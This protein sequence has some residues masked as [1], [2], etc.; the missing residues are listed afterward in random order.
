MRDDDIAKE[1][2]AAAHRGDAAAAKDVLAAP[3]GSDFKA[4]ALARLIA[5]R[6]GAVVPLPAPPPAQL[7]V[8]AATTWHKRWYAVVPAVALAAS[9]AAL[10]FRAGGDA[11]ATAL[12]TYALFVEGGQRTIRGAPEVEPASTRTFTPDAPVAIRLR[13]P[14]A[15]T[16]A[17]DVHVVRIARETAEVAVPLRVSAAGTIE[18]AGRASEVFGTMPGHVDLLVV[19]ARAGTKL[20]LVALAVP[21][22]VPPANVQTVRVSAE[23]EAR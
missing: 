19:L 16:G 13:P 9:I 4:R 12:P 5:E 23:M 15:V 20:D 6:R 10:Y 17:L 8:V 3:L 11:D 2:Q 21:G 18:I 7:R 22:T 14:A 1:L